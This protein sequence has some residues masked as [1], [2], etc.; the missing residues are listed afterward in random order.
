MATMTINDV[1]LTMT[2]CIFIT[3]MVAIGAGVF[4]L[5][6]RVLNEDIKTIT[7]QSVQLAQKGIAEDVAG[8]VGNSASLI[9]SLTQLIRTTSGIG[10]LLLLLGV[11]LIISSYLLLNQI[12]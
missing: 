9:N 10:S 5:I 3:G 12:H 1:T 11:T 8:L 4:I 7:S 6:T 2:I